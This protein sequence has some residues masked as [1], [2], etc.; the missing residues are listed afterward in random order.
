MDNKININPVVRFAVV[1]IIGVA[2]M[3]L[4][5]D[6]IT[7]GKENMEHM[8][9]MN[10]GYSYGGIVGGLLFFLIKCLVIV[11][12]VALIAGI[13]IW[14]KNTFFKDKNINFLGP[15]R[16]D[17]VL[18]PITSIIAA[19]VG[20]IILLVIVHSVITPSMGHNPYMG[21]AGNGMQG[22]MSMGAGYGIAGGLVMIIK[23]FILILM[24][25]LILAIFMYLKQQYDKGMP[26]QNSQGKANVNAND[27]DNQ[28]I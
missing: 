9:N 21:M 11:L 23:L 26:F 13:A 7:G 12:V 15:I 5:F 24:V 14:A 27:P 16:N 2:A 17:P 22:G 1:I 6:Y 18:K 4:L 10:Q 25:S 19:I 8:G 3:N 28:Q 20:V